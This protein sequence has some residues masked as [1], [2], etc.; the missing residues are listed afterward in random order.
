MVVTLN[1]VVVVVGGVVKTPGVVALKPFVSLLGRRGAAKE[2]EM[3]TRRNK[4][5]I[6]FFFLLSWILFLSWT[7]GLSG[8]SGL[9]LMCKVQMWGYITGRDLPEERT[10]K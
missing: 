9:L 4:E 6:F 10:I 8:K 2:E 1:N 5:S 3:G 7:L